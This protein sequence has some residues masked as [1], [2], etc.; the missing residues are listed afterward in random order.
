MLMSKIYTDYVNKTAISVPETYID[1]KTGE[2][3]TV[4]SKVQDQIEYHS[5]NSTLIHLLF[6]ALTTYLHP[7]TINGETEEILFELSEIKK[8]LQ[9]GTYIQN[10]SNPLKSTHQKP[11]ES[12]KGLDLKELEEILDAFGS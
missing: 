10:H 5:Q 8:V 2:S 3:H 11:I 7:R 1:V 6:S 12:L 4:S 9:Q